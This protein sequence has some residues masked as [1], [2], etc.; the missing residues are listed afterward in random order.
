MIDS[1]SSFHATIYVGFREG[2]DGPAHLL[3]E[4]LVVC[5]SYVDQISWCVRVTPCQYVYKGGNEPGAAIG[6]IHYP[7]FPTPVSELRRR[8]LELARKLQ[9]SLGQ[10]RV[11]VE[12][13]DETVML[14]RSESK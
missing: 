6:V 13:P 4:C 11:S 10:Q 8:T 2:H 12:F 3:E 5:Q 1:V 7:R 14:S 9:E